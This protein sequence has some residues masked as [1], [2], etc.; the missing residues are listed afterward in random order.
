MARPKKP[1]RIV[2]AGDRNMG[3]ETAAISFPGFYDL[4]DTLVE[5]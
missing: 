3:A 1:L 2:P 4:L 5:R